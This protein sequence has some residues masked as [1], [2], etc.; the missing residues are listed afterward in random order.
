MNPK[1]V[2][3]TNWNKIKDPRKNDYR[4]EEALILRNGNKADVVIYLNDECV[5][6]GSFFE[7][8]VIPDRKSSRFY[9]LRKDLFIGCGVHSRLWFYFDNEH[10]IINDHNYAYPFDEKM[11]NYS[12]FFTRMVGV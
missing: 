9:F 1:Q 6:F 12:M 10:I 11:K 7:E 4:I 5:A 3:L 2:F 8:L